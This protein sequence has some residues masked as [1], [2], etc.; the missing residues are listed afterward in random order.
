[1]I[2]GDARQVRKRS[3]SC[4]VLRLDLSIIRLPIRHSVYILHADIASS[5]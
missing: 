5:C 2:I 4:A 1:V 3:F